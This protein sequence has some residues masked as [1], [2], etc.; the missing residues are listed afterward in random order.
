MVVPEVV[1]STDYTFSGLGQADEELA[2]AK[3]RR[4]E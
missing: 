1:V 4:W 2:K 3:T